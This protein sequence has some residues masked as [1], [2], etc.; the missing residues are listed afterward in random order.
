MRLE[1]AQ[2]PHAGRDLASAAAGPENAALWRYIPFGPFENGDALGAAMATLCRDHNWIPYLFRDPTSGAANGMASFMRL[3]PEAGSVEIGCIIFSK[4]MQKTPA[5]TEAMYL[6]ARHVFDDL[7]YRRYEWKCNDANSASKRAAARLGFT[8][9]G[10]FRQDMVMKG[11]NRDTAWYSIIDKEWP[12]IRNAFEC[13]LGP[14][15][16]DHNGLQRRRLVEFR[17]TLD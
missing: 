3:R 4:K 13:W 15:N 6:M 10:V 12:Q 9:E 16:F 11:E 8:F 2:F 1:R 17:E 7:G 14:E 5:A